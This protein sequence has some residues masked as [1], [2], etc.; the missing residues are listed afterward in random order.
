[1]RSTLI[2]ALLAVL[3]TLAGCGDAQL[4]QRP[5]QLCRDDDNPGEIE[6]FIEE[7]NC[8]DVPYVWRRDDGPYT[9]GWI[10]PCEVC[11]GYQQL[12]H[13]A[14]ERLGCG[15]IPFPQRS[16]ISYEERAM[17]DYGDFVVKYNAYR[18]ATSCQDI[19]N[20]SWIRVCMYADNYWPGPIG[21]HVSRG[22]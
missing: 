4:A 21:R 18:N 10:T 13:E 19:I 8:G 6:Q 14:R 11:E 12:F 15:D 9:S 16:C 3:V 20:L 17:C 2:T 7:L 22:P 1:M 5:D